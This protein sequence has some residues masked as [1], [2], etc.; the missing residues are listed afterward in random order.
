MTATLLSVWLLASGQSLSQVQHPPPEIAAAGVGTEWVHL[1]APTWKDADRESR[2]YGRWRSWIPSKTKD[3]IDVGEWFGEGVDNL[4][5][6]VHVRM[7]GKVQPLPDERYQVPHGCADVPVSWRPAEKYKDEVVDKHRTGYKQ[8]QSETVSVLQTIRNV[9]AQMDCVW[10]VANGGLLQISR[11]DVAVKDEDWDIAYMC[12]SAVSLPYYQCSTQIG[13]RGGAPDNREAFH[14]RLDCTREQMAPIA[15]R[16][17][18]LVRQ[19]FPDYTHRDD[20]HGYITTQRPTHA[21][22]KLIDWSPVFV[23]RDG[24]SVGAGY[25]RHECTPEYG[26]TL[27]GQ[28]VDTAGEPTNELCTRWPIQTIFPLRPCFVDGVVVPCPFDIG[29]FLSLDHQGAYV[30]PPRQIS[31]GSPI[32]FRQEALAKARAVGLSGARSSSS[33]KK[34]VS[35]QEEPVCDGCTNCLLWSD[36]PEAQATQAVQGT[37]KRMERLEAC[38]FG[39]MLSLVPS[40]VHIPGPGGGHYCGCGVGAKVGCRLLV[41]DSEQGG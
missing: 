19:A 14:E 16:L 12:R 13:R 4:T 18:G 35:G 6:T 37:I 34:G 2:E 20:G 39:N 29:R 32:Q 1:G 5:D 25:F 11:A 7:L 15:T 41:L 21:M 22:P 30:R 3:A 27:R 26:M 9:F 8:E 10:W 23:L 31:I 28:G 17:R 33:S 36:N 24:K 40:L 38:G